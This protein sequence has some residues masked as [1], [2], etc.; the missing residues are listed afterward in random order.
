MLDGEPAGGPVASAVSATITQ[1]CGG[2]ADGAYALLA[3]G[4]D[5]TLEELAGTIAAATT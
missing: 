1:L 4:F 2:H 3:N 5:G